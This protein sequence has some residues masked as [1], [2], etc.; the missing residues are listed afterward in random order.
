MSQGRLQKVVASYRQQLLAREAQA[1]RTLEQAYAHVLATIQP[2]LNKLYKEITDKQ[3]NGETVPLSYLYE[4]K[5]LQTLKQLI[6]KEINQYA[7]LAQMQ[8]GQLQH[9]G[10]TLGQQSAQ[11]MLQASV[12]PGIRYSFG[13]PSQEAIH[14]IVGVTQ[15]GSPLADLF[16]GFGEEAASKTS[17]ALITG[18]SLGYNPR[19]IAP[20]IE[21]ALG[22]SRNRA[23]VVSRQEMLRCYRSAAIENYKAN[24]DVCSGWVWNCAMDSRSCIACIMMNGTEHSLD[25][26]LDGHI[27][28]RCT[29]SPKVRS[30][31]EILAPLGIDTS[32]IPDSSPSYQSGEDW[33][34]DQDESVQRSVLGSNV[35]YEAWKS[36]DVSL[37]QFIGTNHDPDWGHSIYVKSAKQLIGSK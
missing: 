17:Q 34:N 25:E 24:S 32:D 21:Q 4:A 23:L 28:C 18:V 8:A 15:S 19:Q 33:F 5:R 20:M 12:P 2:Q 27:C 35:A 6:Q 36:G 7:A 11:A 31:E 26:D 1:T 37:K 3:A 22:I 14:N 9:I 16:S 13:V 30:W 29:K 10:A